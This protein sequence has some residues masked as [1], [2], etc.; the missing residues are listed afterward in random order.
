[1]DRVKRMVVKIGSNVLILP[2][3]KVGTRTLIGPHIIVDKN[4]EP[5]KRVMLLQQWS[6]T[7][8]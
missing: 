1:M 6:A 5:R 2:G 4:I 8:L 3:R 7:D